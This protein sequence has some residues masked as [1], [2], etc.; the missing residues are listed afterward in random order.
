MITYR[1]EFTGSSHGQK[2]GFVQAK[3]GSRF[4]GYLD[5]SVYHDRP[6][7]KM[8]E[9]AKDYR[10]RGVARAMYLKLAESYP[11]ATFTRGNMT[12]DGVALRAAMDREF[13]VTRYSVRGTTRRPPLRTNPLSV[14]HG[15]KAR[16]SAFKTEFLKAGLF[17]YGFYFHSGTLHGAKNAARH[18]SRVLLVELDVTHLFDPCSDRGEALWASIEDDRK[19]LLKRGDS[20]LYM[21]TIE[22][23]LKTMGYDAIYCTNRDEYVVF[24]ARH[25]RIVGLVQLPLGHELKL[26]PP[27]WDARRR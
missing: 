24:D 27:H 23:W 20:G 6:T 16:F 11:Y 15:T 25:I 22:R 21:R 2:D 4:V 3:D 14:S 26:E 18:G 10:R 13:E 17:G 8:V 12:A 1:I 9:V 19:T 7:V 5:F